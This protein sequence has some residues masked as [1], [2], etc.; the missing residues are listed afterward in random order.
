M[1]LWLKAL[2]VTSVFGVGAYLSGQILWPPSPDIP[3]PSPSQVIQFN[4][5][6]VIESYLFGL[7]IAFLI[8]GWPYVQ[9]VSA[10]SGTARVMYFSLV[11]LLISWWPHDNLH[12]HL[13]DTHD[14]QSLIFIEYTFHLTVIIVSLILAYSF[15]RIL[16]NVSVVSGK[17]RR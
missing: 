11:W 9:K 15:F 12:L 6:Y 4:I 16:S 3:F 14:I 13:Y 7:G 10:H 1:R 5:L 8:L 17:K 2:F